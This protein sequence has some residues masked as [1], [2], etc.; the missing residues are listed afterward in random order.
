MNPA[1]FFKPDSYGHV[2]PQSGLVLWQRPNCS[3][4]QAWWIHPK[5]LER[6]RKMLQHIR[7][8]YANPGHLVS[9]GPIR[10]F[11]LQMCMVT[12][13]E[14]RFII[15]LEQGLPLAATTAVRRMQR[16][17]R[18]HMRKRMRERMLAVCMATHP[19]LGAG[20]ALSSLE[21]GLLRTFF[22][23]K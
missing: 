11:G 7:D 19:R 5:S 23:C 18:E 6:A 15:H 1:M 17:Y 22:A 9:P 20:S 14:E 2:L 4:L 13:D 10:T 3:R 16:A 21:E 12:T 8:I